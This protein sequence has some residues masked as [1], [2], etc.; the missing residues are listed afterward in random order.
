MSASLVPRQR[1]YGQLDC[2]VVDGGEDP[3]IAVVLCHGYGAPGHDLAS[4]SAEWVNLLGERAGEFRFIF[5]AAPDSMAD[6]GMPD[7]RAW[8]PINMAQ[9]AEAVQASRFDELHEHEPEG[10]ARARELLTAA[11]AEARADFP[12][13]TAPLVLGGFSQGAMLALDTS[14][15]GLEEPPALL[16]LFSGTM[17]CRAAW[18]AAAGRLAGTSVF[19]SHGTLDPI[20]PASSAETLRELLGAAGV[21][22]EFHSF[23]GPHTIDVDAISR[24]SQALARVADSSPPDA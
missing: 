22:V 24:T 10:L 13:G 4:L 3:R 18:Q 7:A 2:I 11:V 16:M 14:L 1:R 6:Q 19:Q 15:R 23:I 9:L 12:A 17:L 20:L 8:W 21:T 5:P